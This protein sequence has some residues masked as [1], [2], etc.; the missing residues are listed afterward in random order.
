MYYMMTHE[1]GFD[2]DFYVGQ[3]H[4]KLKDVILPT[5]LYNEE[6]NTGI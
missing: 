2:P 4:C 3:Y 6:R 5:F 1:T